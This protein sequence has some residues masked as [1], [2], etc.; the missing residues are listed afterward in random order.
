MHVRNTI[1]CAAHGNLDLTL[2]TYESILS[3]TRE[4]YRLIMVDNGSKDDTW[5]WMETSPGWENTT[6]SICRLGE[7]PDKNAKVIFIHSPENGG[8]GIGRNIGIRAALELEKIGETTDYITL[9]D[10][11]IVATKGWDTEMIRFMD[12]RP[13]VGLCGPATNYAGTPQLLPKA[14]LP[15]KMDEIWPFAAKYM[16]ENRGRI[17][18][19]PPGF[20][21]VGFCMMIRKEALDQVGLFDERFK[22]Y[23]NEDNDY[24]LRMVQAGW[25]LMYYLGVYVHHW[26]GK[27]LSIL[28]DEGIRQWDA[29]RKAFAE[30]WGR[31]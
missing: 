28:G 16:N 2:I 31:K 17:H 9:I 29:N 14:G 22:L 13:D 15:T 21:V 3:M 8:C 30:K 6:H 10:N 4:S 19:V 26:G 12:S 18:G 5:K 24:C 20:V 11:D 27:T 7:C 25:K 23:G 1:V